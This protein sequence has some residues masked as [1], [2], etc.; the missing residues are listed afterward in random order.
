LT[1]GLSGIALATRLALAVIFLIAG[2]AKLADPGGSRAALRDFGIPAR[3]ARL[4]GPAL[5]LAELA[6]AA[7]LIPATSARWG[8]LAAL[9]LLGGF[10]AAIAGAL[11]KGRKPDCHCFG[12]LH[13]APAGRSTLVR[14]V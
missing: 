5:P 7:A 13:S 12:Q 8:A 4:L 11:A 10:V 3:L 9:V 14:N 2:V 1:H 6:T